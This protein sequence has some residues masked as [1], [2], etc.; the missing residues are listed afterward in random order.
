MIE[1]KNLEFKY[2][3]AKILSI[4]SLIIND[5]DYIAIIGA[6]GCG[7]TTL[8]KH[9]N[10][11]LMPSYGT[12]LVDGIPTK[13]EEK[14]RRKVG[15]LFQNPEDQLINS[16]VD[17]DIAFGPENEKAQRKHIKKR[18][19]DILD[20]LGIASLAKRNVNTLSA[21]QK[22]LVALA[23]VL[24]MHPSY[25]VFDEPTTLL[26]RKNRQMILEMIK[27]INQKRKI[28]VILV[29]NNLDDI[30]DAK[31]IVVLKKG[32]ILFHDE[33]RKLTGSILKKADLE[34]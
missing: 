1:I 16:I 18:V 8:A 19:H 30:K 34:A 29:T 3:E 15:Y 17:E 32:S 10:A 2:E 11:L 28:G 12:V 20:E 31:K 25:I 33:K 26:D 23:G 4:G 5:G 14:V 7:K 6:N 24:V 22:Q 9:L 13:E 21:G 27:S